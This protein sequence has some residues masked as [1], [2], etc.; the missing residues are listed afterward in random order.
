MYAKSSSEFSWSVLNSNDISKSS[1]PMNNFG[2]SLR[3]PEKHDNTI[4]HMMIQQIY[5]DYMQIIYRIM[6]NSICIINTCMQIGHYHAQGSRLH[7]QNKQDSPP[8]PY[9]SHVPPGLSPSLKAPNLP[10]DCCS[11]GW[12]H[13]SHNLQNPYVPDW[14]DLHTHKLT[15]QPCQNNTHAMPHNAILMC[16]QCLVDK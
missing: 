3:N 13:P 16:Y 11:F 1:P 9:M 6:Q 12:A 14:L 4:Y 5:K 15:S 2:S 8:S 10:Q 7:A